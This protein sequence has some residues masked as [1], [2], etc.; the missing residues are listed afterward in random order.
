V[1]LPLN[2]IIYLLEVKYDDYRS[3]LRFVVVDLLSM[4]GYLIYFLENGHKVKQD[5]V[6][7]VR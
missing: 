7:E 5:D 6:V 2:K 3:V 1:Y 4:N